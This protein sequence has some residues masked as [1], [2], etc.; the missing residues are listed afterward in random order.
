[1]AIKM[2]TLLPEERLPVAQPAVLNANNQLCLLPDVIFAGHNEEI[3]TL[4]LQN[5]FQVF[6]SHVC[7]LL[8][9]AF[10][11]CWP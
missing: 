4:A 9:L 11:C 10:C 2:Q 7:H 8:A 5:D 6:F 3:S 1:M